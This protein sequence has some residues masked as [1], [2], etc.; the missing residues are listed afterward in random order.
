[1]EDP[2]GLAVDAAART[3]SPEETGCCCC[4][5]PSPIPPAEEADATCGCGCCSLLA[6]LPAPLLEVPGFI[7]RAERGDLR[8]GLPIPAEPAAAACTAALAA[9][10]AREVDEEDDDDDDD[11]ED[12]AN[13]WATPPP[14]P[15]KLGVDGAEAP[16]AAGGRAFAL[17]GPA[18]AGAASA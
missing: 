3:F 17:V 4:C 1:V 8:P 12:G 9:F 10:A 13:G 6:L 18:A 2:P 5:L 15:R 7:M 14:P 11:T 16:A